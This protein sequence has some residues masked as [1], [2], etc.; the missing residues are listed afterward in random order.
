MPPNAER[1]PREAAAADARIQAERNGCLPL[2]A[3][4]GWP[5]S[6][7]CGKQNKT[8]RLRG[9]SVKV[10]HTQ[11]PIPSVTK[12]FVRECQAVALG[13]NGIV[14]PSEIRLHDPGQCR[15]NITNL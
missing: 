1:Q 3:R 8:S 14:T 7:V 11:K 15:C 12:I 2:A 9:P 10:S 4:F 13:V 5:R 6:L